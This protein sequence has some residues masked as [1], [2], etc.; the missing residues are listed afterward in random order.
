[1]DSISVPNLLALSAISISAMSATVAAFAVSP[2][3]LLIS[4][5][6]KLVTC[7]I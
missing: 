7:S 4:E 3:R 1:M 6:E 5:A 2:L